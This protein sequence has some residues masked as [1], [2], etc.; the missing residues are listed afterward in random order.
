[1]PV[2]AK[3]AAPSAAT[4]FETFDV[5][6]ATHGAKPLLA[7]VYRPKGAGPFPIMIDLHGGAWVNGERAND[8]VLCE[9]MASAGIVVV[10]IDF[11]VPP[12][13]GYPASA[14]D[15]NYAVRW[16]RSQAGGWKGR[17]EKIGLVGISSGGHLAMLAGMRPGDTR[18][19]ALATASVPAAKAEVQCVVLCWPVIDPVGRYRYAKERI[20]G[21]GD[22]PQQ[23]PNVIPNHDMYWG[24][25]AA[26]IEGG[27]PQILERGEPVALPPVLY[28]QG[29]ADQM[30]P[31]AHLDKFV[32]LYRKAGGAL[33]LALYPGEVEGFVT[34]QPK[35]VEN[36]RAA[37]QRIIDFVHKT[38]G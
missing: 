28:V 21:G 31:R 18:Y 8:K 32:A 25:E 34:R 11:R 15:I 38:L 30:H 22:Y 16:A 9:A 14:A 12:E 23:L 35:S 7:T 36:R 26:M 1:M 4:D 27:P 5:T 33:E 20:A 3:E 13:A 10:A 6:Y 17:P 37:T 24:S 19:G 2:V 29:D